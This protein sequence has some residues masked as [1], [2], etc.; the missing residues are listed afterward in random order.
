MFYLPS[1][2]RYIL[3]ALIVLIVL[4]LTQLFTQYRQQQDQHRP[5]SQTNLLHAALR[6]QIIRRVHIL[7]GRNHTLSLSQG[8]D[9][10]HPDSEQ[11]LWAA[12]YQISPSPG[13]PLVEENTPQQKQHH[14]NQ[15]HVF[16]AVHSR[17]LP[18]LTCDSNAI[19]PH[20]S[21]LR[22]SAKIH[23]ISLTPP[24]MPNSHDPNTRFFNPA[25]IPLPH[26]SASSLSSGDTSA[27]AKYVLV[28]RL[29]TTGFHQ[30][31][32]ICL[33]DICLPPT[34]PPPP[35]QDA[36]RS[37]AA[38]PSSN[39]TSS[40][41]TTTNFLPPDTRPCT[42]SD[43]SILGTG[44]GMRCVT[45]PV[46][47]NIPSTPAEHCDVAWL[48]FPDIPGF[49]DPRVFWSG[50][51]EPLI[52]V[53]SA[54]R[55]GCVGLWVVDLRKVF[56]DLATVLKPRRQGRGRD[57]GRGQDKDHQL[58]G[59]R[60]GGGGA[61]TMLM[62]YPHLTE[63]TRNPRSS[64]SLVEKNW[65]MWFPN[66]EEA[67][68]QYEMMG[69]SA[70]AAETG[71]NQTLS[72]AKRTTTATTDHTDTRG[73]KEGK[74]SGQGR[75]RGGRT[76]AKLTGN[77][78]TTRNLTSPLEQ[79]CFTGAHE[80]DQLGQL[81][82][83]HQ[84]SNALRLLLCRRTEARMGQCDEDEA[85]ADG[86]S[87]HFAVVHRKFSNVI[88]LPLRYERYVL[89][90]DSRKPFKMIGVSRFPLLMRDEW[91]RPW[92]ENENWP[93]RGM[94][95]EKNH[96]GNWTMH[97]HAGSKYRRRRGL[98]HQA[99][100]HVFGDGGDRKG[101]DDDENDGDD[102]INSQAYFTYTPS[103]TW[104]WKPHSAGLGEDD[105]DDVEY[106]SRLGM[107][108]LGDEVLVGIGMDDVHQGVAKVK[109][110]HLLQCL[111]LC[112]GVEVAGRNPRSQAADME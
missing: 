22:L 95:K 20:T 81:G 32:H 24:S 17:L 5:W 106:M 79:P 61:G 11:A 18:F 89:V 65:V 26:W 39:A 93:G 7:P 86:R 105:K 112:P 87:I 19:N 34:P 100:S 2:R 31:S 16:P 12:I 57:R 64:R 85:V 59:E 37:P 52:L 92:S 4:I 14:E 63:I 69:R 44:G 13:I 66:H 6:R 50:K 68:V 21:H 103:L 42:A 73:K 80:R 72:V 36:K 75:G 56:P 41:K 8:G 101:H 43:L 51:G 10:V 47:I 53:N 1:A 91:A 40:P 62:S 83:W 109:V 76:L 45:A 3:P 27:G 58:T 46:K 15:Q 49:H 33:A 90:W 25:I 107:G 30:E 97:E 94:D 102:D 29:V 71:M 60:G 55:Y 74:E 110:E 78:F 108:Y 84:G 77:G 48:A 88:D 54:S 98:L 38:A 9:D 99:G 23:N 96:R 104:A 35:P 28:S 67:Y 82:H 111:R 70:L